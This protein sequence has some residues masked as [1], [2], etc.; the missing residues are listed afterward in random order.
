MSSRCIKD[1]LELENTCKKI[2]S[3]VKEKYGLRIS[4]LDIA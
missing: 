2:Q 3:Y 4:Q 1:V